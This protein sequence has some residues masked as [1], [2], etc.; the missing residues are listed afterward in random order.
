MATGNEG[1][2]HGQDGWYPARLIP[3]TGIRGQDEQERRGA[4]VLLAVMQAVPAFGHAL[5]EG[6][7]APKGRMSTYTEVQL[8][9]AEGALSIPDG[10]IVVER[11]K[12]RWS[13][14]VEIKTSSASLEAD[15]VSR[16]LD[17]ARDHGFEAVVTISNQITARAS[18][19]P[20]A[21]D[22]RKLK[23]VDLFHLSWW[24]IITEA[25]LQHRFRG[26]SDPDQAWILGELIAYLDHENSGASGFQDMGE[27]WV[28]VREAARQGTLRAPDKETRS[29]AER[30]EQ[31]S[32]YLALGLSQDLG[33]DV[34]PVRPRNESLH[35][36]LDNLVEELATTGRLASAVRVPDAVGPIGLTADLRARQLTTSIGLDAPREGRPS[37]RINWM[38]RQ[39]ADAPL[40]L[41]VTVSFTNARETTSLLLEEAREFPQRLLSPTDP[42]REPRSFELALTLG[43]GLKSGR[44]Q[45]S[46]VRETRRQLTGFYR[47]VV[48]NLKRWQ[49]AAPKLAEPPP[50]V[51]ET[52][53]PEPPPFA[54]TDDRDVGEATIPSEPPLDSSP[55]Q[56]P[57]DPWRS[58]PGDG[59]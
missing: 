58:N 39:L 26:I 3:V 10:A 13:A 28:R 29:I 43:L 30:W 18:D 22:R 38:L 35:T 49:A 24:R 37:A 9:D 20:V 4:S 19:S 16:Y 55:E 17:M 31:F 15:Q 1:R 12:T 11:G 44:G 46:F 54:A 33:R 21:F 41:R 51:P 45:G 23:K 8:K 57:L 40:N 5:L 6:L 59:S 52:P 32:D 25:V 27:S 14:L 34:E 2:T 56:P 7:G 36:R 53:Q 48:Q 47:D 50:E 42:K